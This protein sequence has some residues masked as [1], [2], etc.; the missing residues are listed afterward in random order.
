MTKFYDRVKETTTTTGT[1]DITLGGASTGYRT[2][3]SVF[4]TGVQ[5]EFYYCIAAGSEWEVGEGYLS[6]STTL[7]RREVKASSN[8]GALVNFSAGTKDVFNTIPAY[9]VMTTGQIR[10]MTSGLVLY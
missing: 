10:A 5:Y 4:P 9:E 7:V 8:G 6:G 3:A 2:F 1:G